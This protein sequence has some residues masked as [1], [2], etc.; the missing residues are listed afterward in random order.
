MNAVLG[1][2]IVSFDDGAVDGED[3]L[4]VVESA[5]E[6]HELRDGAVA[7]AFS[8]GVLEL[9]VGAV[10]GA[11]RL[12]EQVAVR[13][14]FRRRRA[15]LLGHGDVAPVPVEPR[16]MPV[17]LGPVE[18][19]SDSAAV[20]SLMGFAV[21]L[22]AAQGFG[23]SADLVLAGVPK[24]ARLGREAY[25]CEVARRLALR[26]AVV[27]DP[28]VL[29]LLDR[30]DTVVIDAEL[31]LEPGSRTRPRRAQPGA[32]AL[33]AAARAAQV[34]L[35]L[36]GASVAD[37][38]HLGVV[39]RVPV[40]HLVESVHERQ[41][42]GHVVA[43]VTARNPLALRAADL[44]IGVHWQAGAPPWGA[45]VLTAARLSEVALLVS[46]LRP[47]RRVASHSSLPAAAGTAVGTVWVAT[48][49][50]G[51]T[52]AL[53]QLATKGAAALALA[54]GTL[55]GLLLG[56]ADSRGPEP[57]YVGDQPT[58]TT[59]PAVEE[60]AMRGEHGDV[61]PIADEHEPRVQPDRCGQLDDWRRAFVDDDGV[62]A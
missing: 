27:L 23:R 52:S 56:R 5:E 17:P 7:Q 41:R 26:D 10:S 32:L 33:V 34:A 62:G 14:V 30:I 58:M 53:A 38:E 43:V 54:V 29:R 4:D 48:A 19:W 9:G 35:V 20:L 42:A 6:A 13:D 21:S 39:E 51:T 11:D 44:G 1:E 60:T 12:R 25:A 3:L 8:Q 61:R 31:L 15:A 45:D 36:A 49:P 59:G 24:A 47:A 18:R 40:R 55:N 28:G 22:A 46:S 2:V 57:V 50:P 16:P 37:A